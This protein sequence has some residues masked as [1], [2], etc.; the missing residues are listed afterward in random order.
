MEEYEKNGTLL[1]SSYWVLYIIHELAAYKKIDIILENSEDIITLYQIAA[2]IIRDIWKEETKNEK[3][4][5]R[6]YAYE[7]FFKKNKPMKYID[8]IFDSD[9]IKEYFKKEKSNTDSK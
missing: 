9:K 6:S 2:Q 4:A 7:Q 3:G 5:A 8:R 1:Y